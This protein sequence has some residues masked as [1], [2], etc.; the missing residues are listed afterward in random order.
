MLNL[1][2]SSRVPLSVCFADLYRTVTDGI[3]S[4]VVHEPNHRLG[5][6]SPQLR[7]PIIMIG[8]FG[9]HGLVTCQECTAASG[10]NIDGF[11]QSQV[12]VRNQQ[13][14]PCQATPST[15]TRFT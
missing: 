3:P 6:Y 2:P 12:V 1:R 7:S 10:S 13:K 8:W 14:V 5:S 15:W 11:I 9:G 4:L